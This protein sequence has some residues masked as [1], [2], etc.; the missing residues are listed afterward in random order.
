MREFKCPA[1]QV[2]QSQHLQQNNIYSKARQPQALNILE[3]IVVTQQATP[4]DVQEPMTTENKK[5]RRQ[6]APETETT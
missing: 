1:V 2:Q 4:V 3:S 5:S 6:K